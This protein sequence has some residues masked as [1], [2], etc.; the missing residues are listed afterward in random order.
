MINKRLKQ[1][2]QEKNLLQKDVAIVLN[3]T[4]S[5]YGFYEQG[6]RTPDVT[7]IKKLAEFYNVTVDYLLGITDIP[8]LEYNTG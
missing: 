6:K 2:R 7:T 3:I 4:T 8:N 5:A 1:L